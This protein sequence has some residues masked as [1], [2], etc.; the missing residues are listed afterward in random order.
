M[1]L[2]IIFFI[3]YLFFS[4][5]SICS[6]RLYAREFTILFIDTAREISSCEFSK[7]LCQ[8]ITGF[9]FNVVAMTE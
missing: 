3:H 2:F 9:C 4:Y 5:V 6:I 1:L 8:L 7:V